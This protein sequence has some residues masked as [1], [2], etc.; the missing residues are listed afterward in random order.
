MPWDYEDRVFVTL[1]ED[2]HN[3]AEKSKEAVLMNMGVC[4][5]LDSRL[6]AISSAMGSDPGR[7]GMWGWALEF[8]S[9]CIF[10]DASLE[11][12]ASLDTDERI[13]SV[14]NSSLEAIECIVEAMNKAS[15]ASEIPKRKSFDEMIKSAPEK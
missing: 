2:C 15:M 11:L 14:R 4:N 13:Q 5:R 12:N 10:A 3:R 1:C 8:I 9:D 6:L 7:F